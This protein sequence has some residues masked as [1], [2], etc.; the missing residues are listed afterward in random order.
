MSQGPGGPVGGVS[1]LKGSVR[2]VTRGDQPP[3]F[4]TLLPASAK[5]TWKRGATWTPAGTSRHPNYPAQ[6]GVN[7]EVG[8]SSPPRPTRF[9]IQLG[10]GGWWSGRLHWTGNERS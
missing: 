3:A 9:R 6:A 1:E 4:A 8:G 5:A 7:A 10:R 2:L